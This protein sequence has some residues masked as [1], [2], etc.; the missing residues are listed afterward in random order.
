LWKNAEQTVSLIVAGEET[1]MIDERKVDAW[2]VESS[3]GMRRWIAKRT[4]EVIQ[5]H[6][7]AAVGGR[8]FWGIRR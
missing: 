4:G 6:T 1:V 5:E 3:A 2:I 7:P 8:E